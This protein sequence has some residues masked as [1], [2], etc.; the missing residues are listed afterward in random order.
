MIFHLLK[1]FFLYFLAALF[2][3]SPANDFYLP[4]IHATNNMLGAYNYSTA[5]VH[6][7]II[8]NSAL[9]V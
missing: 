8:A 1:L 4:F 3:L 6:D 5:L 7:L 2:L 9:H